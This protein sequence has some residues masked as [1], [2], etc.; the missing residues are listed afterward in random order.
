MRRR[1]ASEIDRQREAL[2]L[3]GIEREYG[4]SR[5][6]VAERARAGEIPATPRGRSLL[7]L[8]ADFEAYMRAHA[9]RP[10]ERARQVV[11]RVL[12]REAARHSDP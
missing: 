12:A 1:P 10:A 9:I 4:Y 6:Y 8:R 3:R 5:T 7:V 11:D 2:S